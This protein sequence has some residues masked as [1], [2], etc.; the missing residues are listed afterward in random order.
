MVKKG[1]K[2]AAGARRA[3]LIATEQE[4]ITIV[5]PNELGDHSKYSVIRSGN[6]FVKDIQS[7]VQL[8]Q[9]CNTTEEIRNKVRRLPL[10][11]VLPLLQEL[12]A[13][14]DV[15]QARDTELTEWIKT[16]LLIHT[17]Y[18][19]TLPE[20]VERL[21]NLYK[22]LDDRLTVYPK[23]LAMHGRLDL[24]Q[25][26][27]DARNKKD[28]SDDELD[29]QLFEESEDSDDAEDVDEQGSDNDSDDDLMDMDGDEEAKMFGEEEDD[30]NTED[31]DDNISDS[32]IED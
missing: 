7:W 26:Q 30:L 21:S 3:S 1:S 24:I 15:Q 2:S 31:E 14:F 22:E 18:F 9:E 29:T 20:I 19:M 16:V 12:L 13:K 17:A 23:L 28:D 8:K 25:N 4:N 10:D 11:N 27:I 32:D 5:K 6:D